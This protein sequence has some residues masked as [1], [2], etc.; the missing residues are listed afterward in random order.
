[1]ATDKIC[2]HLFMDNKT[3]LVVGAS[4]NPARFSHACVL[5]LVRNKIL[6]VALGLR[7]GVIG[8][9][10]IHTGT[11]KFK[12]VH[13]ITLYVKASR[14]EALEEYLLALNPQRIIFNP[15]AENQRLMIKARE[16]GVEVV[17]ACTL[18]M[19]NLGTF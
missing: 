18:R 12:N 19:L 6:V 1:M 16:H 13:T 4:L 7:D 14:L 2:R 15:G 17:E 8:E 5:C 10:G 11:P 3:T 9:I